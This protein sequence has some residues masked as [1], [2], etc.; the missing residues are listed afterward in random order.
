[1]KKKSLKKLLV[2]SVVT[3]LVLI[4]TGCDTGSGMDQ[5]VV[6]MAGEIV[7]LDPHASNDGPSSLVNAQIYDTLV[8]QNAEG[9][10]LPRLA[11]SWDIIDERTYE[12]HLKQGVLFH[13]GEELTAYDVEFTFLRAVDSA[14][15]RAIVGEVDPNSIVVVDEHTIRISSFS[16]FAPFLNHLAH[17]AAS[18]LS[19]TAI[20]EAEAEG[21][22][23][24]ETPIGTGP[25]KFANRVVGD[26]IELERFED[27]HGD[28]PQFNE[29]I[30]RIMREGGARL[31][32][33][34]IGEID[35]APIS[36]NDIERVEGE[37]GITLMRIKGY[38]VNYVGM[39]TQRPPF[40][41]P[42]VRQAVNYAV[43]VELIHQTV[44][45]GVG[46]LAP[47]PIGSN[48]WGYNPNLPRYGFDP[49]RA[50]ELLAEAGF[51]DGFSTVIGTNDNPDRV[52]LAQV[53]AEQLR[54]VGIDV[55]IESM[56]F[57]IYLEDVFN[58]EFDMFMSG[59]IA[60]TA[61]ADY[62]LY[63][64]F[65]SSNHGP[66]GN[67][68]FI[69]NDRLDELLDIARGTR[70][71]EVRLA[72]YAEAQEIIT[73]ESVWILLDNPEALVGVRDNVRGLTLNPAGHHRFSTAYFS[74]S[75]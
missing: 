18:I 59:W 67:Q 66:P 61:D 4:V 25:F 69:A 14:S 19:R 20:E 54:E 50:R 17:P 23:P 30:F 41:N 42:L 11:E 21:I 32:A 24:G 27:Y 9:E 55:E 48:I 56:E 16:P 31:M 52:E 74:D 28:L 71:P 8:I 57:A 37:E 6:G 13:N 12:F 65:H 26:R 5:F 64:R 44:L 72:A 51:P 33:L 40:D 38:Q 35:F 39:N 68:T 49:E 45:R 62:G 46:V 1:M 47:G 2:I 15:I 70:D 75:D 43:D 60:V 7:S 10:I 63:A 34:E 22:E 73:A 58:G 29:L 36:R 53:I 3:V